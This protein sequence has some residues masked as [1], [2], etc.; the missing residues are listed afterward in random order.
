MHLLSPL[1]WEAEAGGEL[2]PP[3]SRPAWAHSRTLT[4]TRT[5]A[6]TEYLF[7]LNCVAW[8]INSRDKLTLPSESSQLLVR[9][10]EHRECSFYLKWGHLVKEWAWLPWAAGRVLFLALGSSVRMCGIPGEQLHTK[11]WKWWKWRLAL[12]RLTAVTYWRGEPTSPGV[13]GWPCCSI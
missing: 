2:E 9:E 11:F 10:R 8:S 6:L 3:S 4:Q 13:C 12:S 7:C 5:K 1:F